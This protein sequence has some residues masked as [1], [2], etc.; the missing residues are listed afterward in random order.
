MSINL[1]TVPVHFPSVCIPR[2]FPN[3]DE[4]R[5]RK[6]F[7]SL[8]IGEIERI[9]IIP[10]TTEKREK[11]N[12][13]FI[14]WRYWNDNHMAN[15]SRERLL[16]GKEIKV[17]YDDPWFWKVSAY[18]EPLPRPPVQK[19]LEQQRPRPHIVFEND[20]RLPI[21]PGLNDYRRRPPANEDR[22]RPP[23]NEDH[24]RRP[25]ANEDRRRP[26]ANEDRRRPPATNE[27]RRRP[28]ANED[29]R[30]R[31]PAAN[32]DRRRP[33]ANEDHRRRPPANEDRVSPDNEKKQQDNKVAITIQEEEENDIEQ[34]QDREMAAIQEKFAAIQE[35]VIAATPQDI[36][37][38]PVPKK[39]Q[40]LKN[41]QKELRNRK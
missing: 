34:I 1:T 2:V 33:P 22:R 40:K 27:D 32:E 26:P 17:M 20:C 15:L 11:F 39:L 14:H 37:I 7:D 23:A 30:R 36:K 13:V 19:R 18:R 35:E 25:P 8:S 9:D 31:P 28:P 12:R 41:T 38:P 16:N 21:A 5:I 3:I 24:R 29:H 4:T 6:V 10:I